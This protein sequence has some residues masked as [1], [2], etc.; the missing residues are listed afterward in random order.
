VTVAGGGTRAVVNG[1]PEWR[2]LGLARRLWRR[3]GPRRPPATGTGLSDRGEPLVLAAAAAGDRRALVGRAIDRRLLADVESTLGVLLQVRTRAAGTAAAAADGMRT[4]TVPLALSDGARAQLDVTLSA[5]PVRRTTRSTI[6]TAAG[7]G[8]LVCVL[9]VGLLGALLRRSVTDPLGALRR[10]IE[11]MRS[12][13]YRVRLPLVGASE[14]QS[15]SEGFNRMCELVGT[16][17]DRLHALANT[18][19]LTGLANHRTFHDALAGASEAS[20]NAGVSFAVVVLDLDRFKVLND[21][22]GHARGDEVLRRLARRLEHIVRGSDLLGRLGGDEFGILLPA[23]DGD[24]ALAVAE[25]ARAAIGAI[26]LEGYTID[27]SAGVACCPADATEGPRVLELADAALYQ[28]KLAGGEQT[29]RFDP[30]VS[31]PGA[32]EERQAVVREPLLAPE[33][34]NCV[35]QPIVELE[36]GAVVGYEALARFNPDRGTGPAEWFDLARS[37]GL[38]PELQA[39]GVTRAL[40]V[41]GRPV[42]A[43]LSVNVD[44]GAFGSESVQAA[45]SG[46]LRGIV[47]EITEQE[48]PSDDQLLQSQLAELRTRGARIA[49]DDAGAGYAGLSHV[50]RV[51]PDLIKLDRSLVA[52]VHHD[53]VRFALIEA[54]VSFA[55]RTGAEVCAEGIETEEQLVALIEAQVM[56]GQGYGLARP[57]PPWV[58]VP[59]EVVEQVCAGARRSPRPVPV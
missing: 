41:P 33:T 37:C 56:L 29:C 54:F 53:D 43:W 27:S 12:G 35:F 19:S 23:A 40:G 17:R 44:P 24:A 46:D 58:A 55:R 15:V 45:F 18:D 38:G 59:P 50:V 4:V 47:I 9:L 8:L 7:A 6:L 14:V 36:R 51:R 22:C 49:L 32:L 5:Q 1:R 42:G 16:Q 26:E 3:A 48:L 25:R 57:A 34:M 39:L 11:R 10:G 52:D 21:A 30:R 20:T 13:D 2:E 31:G 28:A